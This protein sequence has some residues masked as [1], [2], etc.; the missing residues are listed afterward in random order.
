MAASDIM[1]N[2][3][4]PEP[5]GLV[6]VEAMAAGCAVVALANGGPRDIVEDGVSGVLCPTRE[7]R[8]LAAAIERLL[9]DAGLRR[10][11]G[12]AARARV[13][14]EFS[15]EAMAQRFANIVRAVA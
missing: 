4:A 5:F 11:I 6:V 8:V 10:E 1:V 12:R 2:A 15:R 14:A 7:P 9:G 3:S 13:E